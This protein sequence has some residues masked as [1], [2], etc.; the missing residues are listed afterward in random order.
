MPR[1]TKKQATKQ[2][3]DEQPKQKVV[4]IPEIIEAAREDM[5]IA[6]NMRLRGKSLEDIA[7]YL[8]V[9]VSEIQGIEFLE[10][11]GINLFESLLGEIARQTHYNDAD[12][13]LRLNQVI[14]DAFLYKGN[15]SRSNAVIAISETIETLIKGQARLQEELEN[16]SLEDTPNTY[17][18]LLKEIATIGLN[19]SKLQTDLGRIN[20]KQIENSLNANDIL[21]L[22]PKK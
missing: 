10:K 17:F 12:I 14:I 4:L 1:N 13:K 22:L 8:K 20:R 6:L 18:R 9:D 3:V 11:S 7:K 2:P 21:S 5:V 15:T 16:T 19:I